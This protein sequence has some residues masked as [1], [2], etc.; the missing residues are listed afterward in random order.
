AELDAQLRDAAWADDVERA[1]ALI[2]RGADVNAKDD[3][4]QSAYLIATSEGYLELLELTLANGAR[5]DDKDSWNG[6]GLI[7]AAE[8]GHAPVVGRLLQAG[9]ERDHVNRIGYQAIHEAVWLGEDTA[10]YRDT[11]RVLIAGGVTLDR[12]SSREGLTPLEMARQRGY[13]S[14]AEILRVAGDAAPIEDPD[15]ALLRAARGGDA[16]AAALAIRAGADLEARDDNDRTPLLLAAANDRVPVARLLVALGADP[17]ALDDRH[18]TPWLVTGVTGSVRMLEALLPA[19]PDLTI[20]NR[21]GGTALIPASERGHA[22]YVARVLQTGIDV[23]HVND[24]GWTA[25]LEAVI[26]GDGGPEHQQVVR[27]LLA[28]GADTTIP[29]RDGRTALDHARAKG[30]TEIVR[31]LADG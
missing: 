22:D 4:Q 29:D 2:D 12:P 6:T 10:E 27:L 28:A 31:L 11:V 8:R 21:F 5:V 25:L 14:L 9:I 24:L 20:R 1:A 19:D 30:Y 7:R 15:V 3:T 23:D 26:L 17:D 16:D 18:D 13:A